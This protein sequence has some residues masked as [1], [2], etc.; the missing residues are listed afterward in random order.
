MST[1]TPPNDQ[2]PPTEPPTVQLSSPEPRSPEVFQLEQD[3]DPF[4]Q[5]DDFFSSLQITQFEKRTTPVENEPEPSP[6]RIKLNES[7]G[8]VAEDV[9]DGSNPFGDSDDDDMAL[10]EIADA[11][12]DSM[13]VFGDELFPVKTNIVPEEDEH[14]KGVPVENRFKT[15]LGE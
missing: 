11:L 12:E 9:V 15:S 6:K 4:S 10:C 13:E 3:D 14:E 8:S 7:E 1:P 5:D 2:L